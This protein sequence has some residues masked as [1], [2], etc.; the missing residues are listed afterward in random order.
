[1]N[2]GFIEQFIDELG[3]KFHI[4]EI[5]FDRWGIANIGNILTIAEQY[6]I[7]ITPVR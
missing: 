5:A 7:E 2:Y 4:K 3:K 6:G 1:M